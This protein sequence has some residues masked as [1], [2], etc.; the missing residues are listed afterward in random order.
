MDEDGR[1]SPV[2]LVEDDF[3]PRIAEVHVTVVGEQP[4]AVEMKIVHSRSRRCR[5]RCTR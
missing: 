1:G 2:Q 5:R 4:N 3:E